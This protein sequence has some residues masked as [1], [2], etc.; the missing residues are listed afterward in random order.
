MSPFQILAACFGLW[1]IYSLSIHARKKLFGKA[2]Y[3][4][5]ISVWVLFIVIALFPD[6]L[7]GISNRLNFSRVFDLLIVAAFIILT[8]MVFVSY[9]QQQELKKKMNDLIQELATRA[10]LKYL[11]HEKSSPRRK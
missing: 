6:L 11:E 9:F 3:G 1:M 5:W 7:L 10:G 4:L 2:E 8:M